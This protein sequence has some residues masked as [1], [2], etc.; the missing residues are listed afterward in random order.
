MRNQFGPSMK[1]MVALAASSGKMTL[2]E[3]ASKYDVHPTQVKQWRDQLKNEAAGLLVENSGRRELE[4]QV[5]ELHRVIGKRYAELE[6]LKKRRQISCLRLA[7]SSSQ[8]IR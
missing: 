1:A 5:D 2:N 4:Q 8:A 7:C 6:W 3:V